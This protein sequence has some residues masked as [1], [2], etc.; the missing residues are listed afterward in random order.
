MK[1]NVVFVEFSCLFV[2][3]YRQDS[4]FVHASLDSF[5]LVPDQ[6]CLVS[7]PSENHADKKRGKTDMA[8]TSVV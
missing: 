8:L 4:V 7:K 3:R 5:N 2:S 1:L 6:G